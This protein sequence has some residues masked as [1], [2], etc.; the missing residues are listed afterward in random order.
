MKGTNGPGG[1]H[2]SPIGRREFLERLGAV[3]AAATVGGP[4]AAGARSMDEETP[5]FRISLAQWSLHR[6]LR[7]GELLNPDFPAFA[8]TRFGIEAV[9]YVSTFFKDRA[10]DRDYLEDLRRRAVDAGVRSLLIMVDGEGDLGHPDEPERTAAVE[11][12]RPWLEAAGLL[13]CHCIR[14]NARSQGTRQEQRDRAADGLRRLT[15][16][17]APLALDVVVENHGG[18]SSDGGWLAE[19]IRRV[20]HPRCGTLPDFGNFRI[21]PDR[22]YD[23]YRG[24]AELMPF[25][26][27][28]S[29]KSH[30]FDGA[31]DET[32]TDYR[33]MMKI[34][35]D[36]GY[37]GWVGVEYEGQRLSE[38]EGVLA[39]KKLLERVRSELEPAYRTRP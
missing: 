7:A 37:R 23:R 28:V 36:A 3:A 39:T 29:A 5:L 32:Q 16:L 15:E 10:R 1:P 22:W 14:V 4:T 12:H 34:V 19:V 24:V 33:R 38:V 2:A 27:A 9:E 31:G 21:D 25:A 26:R 35:L 11:R 30:D 6:M 13:G 18:L 20:G 8:R 17:A